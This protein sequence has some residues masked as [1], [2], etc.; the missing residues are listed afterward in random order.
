MTY[1]Y[2]C[3][4]CNNVFDVEQSI[5]DKPIAECPECLVCT[6]KR[7]ITNG[8]FLLKGDGWAKDQYSKKQ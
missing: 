6:N 3:L 7:L 5:K 2:H 4:C 8:N 1:T